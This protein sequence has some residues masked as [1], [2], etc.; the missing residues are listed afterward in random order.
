MREFDRFGPWIDEVRSAEDVPR[1]YRDAGLDPT[2]CLLV[3][4]VPRNIERR[5]AH[6]GM[7]LYDYLLA[8][9][10]ETLTVLERRDDTYGTT[11]IPLDRIAALQDSV[12]LLD[13]RL[14]IHRLDGPAVVVPYNGSANAPVRDLIRLIRRWYLPGEPAVGYAAPGKPALSHRDTGLV[15]DYDRLI[16]EEPGMRLA[17]VADRQVVTP[18]SRL[19]QLWRRARPLTLHA[20]IIVADERELQLIH[21]RDWFTRQSNDISL[22]RTVL[23]RAR[24]TGV[25]LIPHHRYVNIDVVTVNAGA[26]A[27]DLP[28]TAGSI[29]ED[30]FS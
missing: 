17:T 22:A 18:I 8:L 19:E 29:A 4:K 12:R 9:D 21:R 30:V 16:A 27:I 1:L 3:L 2:A 23:P 28:V 15:T 14:T 24:L 26:V 6:P 5:D 10:H 11:R 20:A 25:Q 13:G 7:H